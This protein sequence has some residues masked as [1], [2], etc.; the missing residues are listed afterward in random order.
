MARDKTDKTDNIPVELNEWGI[1][2]WRRKKAYGDVRSWT[3]ERWR[4][5]FF[6]RRDDLRKCF[7]DRADAQYRADQQLLSD[8]TICIDL[9]KGRPTEPGFAVSFRECRDLF[10]YL[11]LPNPRIGD[12]PKGL[13]VPLENY[14]EYQNT[15]DGAKR[16]TEESL[17]RQVK[18]RLALAGVSLTVE[19]E[20]NLEFSLLETY[21]ISLDSSQVAVKFDLN[22]PLKPQLDQAAK[23]L[24][25]RQKKLHGKSFESAKHYRDKWLGYLR[26]I[27]GKGLNT[28]WAEMAA[29]FGD[30]GTLDRRKAPEGGYQDPPGTAARDLF[31]AGD[32]LR[33][34]L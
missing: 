13:I 25:K 18:G 23:T 22:K 33:N 15:L 1:P 12:Q 11:C 2:D 17:G 20:R 4:W 34:N 7:D 26:A 29:V 14:W 5:E 27:D 31:K 6:R 21:P 3:H 30:D 10:G 8:P 32:S 19:Q 9:F 28:S 24:K 16:D